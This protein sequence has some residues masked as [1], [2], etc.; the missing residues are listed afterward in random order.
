MSNQF[1]C[2]RR[3]G[4]PAAMFLLLA[5]PGLSSAQSSDREPNDTMAQAVQMVLPINSIYGEINP[6][7]DVD[8]YKFTGQA[9]SEIVIWVHATSTL[10]P[11]LAFYDS[12]GHLLAYN[13]KEVNVSRGGPAVDPILYIKIRTTGIYFVSV[14]SR[15]KFHHLSEGATSGSYSLWAFPQSY[16]V[17]GMDGHEPNDTRATAAP[18]NLPFDSNN[19]DLT[20]LGDIDWFWFRGNA[21]NKVSIDI[22]A[23]EPQS[24]PDWPMTMVP[25]VGLFDEGG[26]LL[27][28]AA[29]GADPENGFPDDPVLIFDL[30]RNGRYF[31]GVTAPPDS[32]YASLLSDADFQADPYVSSANGLIGHYR[33]RIQLLHDLYFPQIAN[34]SFGS[35]YFATNVI[36]LNPNNTESSGSISFFKSDGTPME[37]TGS[38]PGGSSSTIWFRIPPKADFVFKSDGTGPGTSGYARVR[39]TG[40]VGGSA[41]FSE[42]T[43]SGSLI[44]EAAVGA[45]SPMDFFTFPV[46][47]TGDFN[48]G[49]A[50][51]NPDTASAINV[52]LNLLDLSGNLIATQ[53]ITLDA[54]QQMAFYVSGI[55]QLFPS[56]RNFRGS[57]QVLADVPVPAVALRI[58]DRTMTTLPAVPLDQGFQPTTTYFPQV[59]VGPASA[60]YRS[61]IVLVNPGYFAVSGTIRFV[62][63]D[64]SPMVF[65]IGSA[66]SGSSYTFNIR[67]QGTLFLESM[68]TEMLMTGYAVLTADHG[69]G[70]V[71]IFSQFDATGK[72]L[73]E[74]AVPPAQPSEDFLVFAQSD[75]GYNTGVALANIN[76]LASGLIYLLRPDSGSGDLLENIPGPL[77][78]GKHN[79]AL[80][81]G[82]DQLFPAFSGTGA[83]EVRSAFPIPA[84]ALRLTATTMTAVPVV[85]V[86]K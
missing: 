39:V 43:E 20:Y 45:S 19:A 17:F 82:A 25:R 84:V 74:A 60:S 53:N 40:T 13:D 41:I 47:I 56:L 52:F 50:V 64:G 14:C 2:L 9:D 36:L 55:G 57:L 61:T 23:L 5:L 18:I 1:H 33:L 21:G 4:L 37:V 6:S 63:S 35:V 79:A 65:G 86:V 32:H 16:W 11:I 72:L 83:L 8:F 7:Q 46:D 62:R 59:V 30:P 27:G 26:H 44:T 10:E 3:L 58:S 34:G 69:L 68:P 66:P 71:V 81:S 29:P 73:T 80:I 15:A 85:P 49:V 78:A 77:E 75:S 31:I 76:E 42:Y 54:G 51:A 12:N 67:P 38:A 70:G 22:E 24:H 48:T 28:E